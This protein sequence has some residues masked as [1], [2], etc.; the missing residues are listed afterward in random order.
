V[1]GGAVVVVAEAAADT[2][3][4]TR[5]SRSTRAT[6]ILEASS[7]L[8]APSQGGAIVTRV[9]DRGGLGRDR[10]GPGR[11]RP[12]AAMTAVGDRLAARAAGLDSAP[13]G[14]DRSS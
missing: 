3:D 14:E 6:T 1:S 5:I 12:G 7:W 9:V 11:A 13:A 2:S 4:K 8:S 10:A